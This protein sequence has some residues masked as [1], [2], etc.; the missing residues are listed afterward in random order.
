MDKSAAMKSEV[1]GMLRDFMM[2]EHGKRIKPKAISV[3]MITAKPK[4]SMEDA[5]EEASE[6]EDED[7]EFETGPVD[8]AMDQVNAKK[9]DMSVEDW[10]DSEGDEEA[11]EEAMKK[12][13]VMSPRDYF[14]RK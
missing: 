11:D 12:T 10:E 8:K 1:L 13:G 4:G 5:L 2:G 6:R 3:E 14:K 7:E 9:N